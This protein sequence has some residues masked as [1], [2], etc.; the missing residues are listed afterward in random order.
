MVQVM[1]THMLIFPMMCTCSNPLC[2]THTVV[3]H[4]L[5]VLLAS[6]LRPEQFSMNFR[7]KHSPWPLRACTV[8]PMPA[9]PVS[10]LP[11]L[12]EIWPT[13]GILNMLHFFPASRHCFCSSFELEH[14]VFTLLLS[15]S[16]KYSHSSFRFQ[17]LYPY[18]SPTNGSG[19][20]L[21]LL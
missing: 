17:L 20:H 19:C 21:L 11:G 12:S 7:N 10:F 6:A 14:I 3:L 2:S 18:R 8:R 4:W 5:L 1:N 13:V 15:I 16:T 9:L